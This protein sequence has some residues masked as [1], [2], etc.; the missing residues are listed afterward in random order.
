M[1]LL[2]GSE[3]PHKREPPYHR[4]KVSK[5]TYNTNTVSERWSA[6]SVCAPEE[7]VFVGVRHV[8]GHSQDGDRICVLLK[9]VCRS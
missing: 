5:A 6:V 8:V 2:L 3:A 7:N 9:G 4:W 1:S